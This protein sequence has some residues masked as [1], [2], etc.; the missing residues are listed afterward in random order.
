[1]PWFWTN[2]NNKESKTWMIFFYFEKCT[3]MMVH[4]VDTMSVQVFTSIC[5]SD[6]KSDEFYESG[7]I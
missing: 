3:T 4:A 1:M 5:T 7:K 6:L 2:N